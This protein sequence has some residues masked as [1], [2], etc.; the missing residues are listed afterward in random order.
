MKEWIRHN[1]WN[2]CPVCDQTKK[3]CR[4]NVQTNVVHCRGE[5]PSPSY[6]FLKLDKHGF[7]MFKLEAEIEE[8]S[9]QKKQDW[10]DQ[11]QR[12]REH[13]QRQWEQ[14]LK[15]QLSDQQRD[16]A[17][18]E[19]LSQ[20]TLTD[21]HRDQLKARGLTDEQI[22]EA[23]YR[24]VTQWQPLNQKVTAQLA[25]VSRDGNQLIT[26][27]SGIIVP[28]PNE[29]GQWVG[30]QLRRDHPE[31]GN[32]Y[33][34]SASERTRENRPTVK[35]RDGELPL[36]VWGTP[37]EDGV[38]YLCESP[39]IKPYLASLRLNHPVIGAAGANFACSP[40][41]LVRALIA[42]EA[43]KLIILPDAGAMINPHI[44]LQ[45]TKTANLLSD[46][47]YSVQFAWWGQM[48]KTA[49]DI[50]EISDD[51]LANME[52]LEAKDYISQG[53]QEQKQRQTQQ[54]QSKLHCLTY[55]VDLL[56][57]DTRLPDLASYIPDSGMI[58]LKSPKA[59]GKSWQIKELRKLWEATGKQ[60]I[61]L[62]PRIALGRTQ[63]V[64]WEINWIDDMGRLSNDVS[65]G[66][67]WDSLQKVSHLDW[68]DKILIIDEAELGIEHL[69]SSATC[70]AQRA[71][72][73][74]IFQQKVPECLNHGGTVFLSDADLTDVPVDY[75]KALAPTAPIFTIVNQAQPQQ[76]RVAF[77]TG[78]K[79]ETLEQLF[80]DLEQ[81][82][83]IT[84]ATD[85][86]EEAEALQRA[87]K[88][89]FPHK[90]VDRVDGK[91]C[92]ENY[93][94]E[95]VQDSN[96]NIEQNQPDVLIYTPSMGVGV[97]ITIDYF[98][99]VY[100]LFH[101]VLAPKD[102]RQMLG[103]I[104][105]AV[106]RIV[107][108]REKGMI[109][110]DQASFLPE[111]IKK[112]I[113]FN[114]KEEL[115]L[116]DLVNAMAPDDDNLEA[117]YQVLSE[118][119]NEGKWDNVHLETYAKIKARRNYGLSQLALQLR[120][121]LIEQGH[122]LYD[123][124]CC[125]SSGI[126][127]ALRYGKEELKQEQATAIA[128]AE[129]ISLEEAQDMSYQ[130]SLTEEERHQMTKAFLKEELPEA[131][132]TPDFVLNAVVQD[133]RKWL[134]A[135]KL[136]WFLNNPDLAQFLDQRNWLHHAKQFAEGEI[137]LPDV[138]S[139]SGKIKLLQ[140]IGLL[141][142]LD[143]D[144]PDKTFSNDD[145]EVQAFKE[146]CWHNRKRLRRLFGITVSKNLYPI[147]LLGMLAARIGLSLTGLPQKRING[148]QVRLYQVNQ[149]EL[150]TPHRIE[151]LNALDRKGEAIAQ[152]AEK[153]RAQG[154]HTP[155]GIVNKIGE[156][157]TDRVNAQEFSEIMNCQA[158][159]L[160]ERFRMLWSTI[161]EG[162][163]KFVQWLRR[164]VTDPEIAKVL[165]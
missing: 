73:L 60:I 145:E 81:G 152:K 11:K 39:G 77:Q 140:D 65:V 59:S 41:A 86:Q 43:K 122:D 83:K 124:Y 149:E 62:T 50:D 112:N 121:E 35:N 10:L 94:K 16:G 97:S 13:R 162:G 105:T 102:C 92:Q 5:N 123:F 7:G 23:G 31:D 22:E 49:G 44:H 88:A 100:G 144:N 90:R 20:L 150:V 52:S 132:L 33:I 19:I 71:Q 6:R 74:Q 1:H 45:N 79:D 159:T 32:K 91:T 55:P 128:N 160:D 157:V 4:T 148:K 134:N 154:C 117:I 15:K 136:F 126:G 64:E 46:W 63:A 87:I 70:K 109:N 24:S 98:D 106:P 103:R 30:Y 9:E 82:L 21:D 93:G 143:L 53:W 17:I 142:L 155:P 58:N 101:G 130:H 114:A 138:R 119:R 164:F 12:E 66:L 113:A 163:D 34:W 56:L 8:F 2:P 84:V 18:R 99:T 51:A 120:Q 26:P 161:A 137:F 37:N 165:A 108:C 3:G 95:W 127:D 115:S 48:E 28:I 67:C 68:R 118:I 36:G 153:A 139:Y 131:E 111:V 125:D 29:K 129:E 42:L 135:T 107:W 156:G 69:L 116:I 141:E 54:E 38:V 151:V 14:E 133:N 27:D 57:N 146:R 61:S 158:L 72:I 96:G 40:N 110:D 75:I 76:W 47:G 80:M 147:Q 89:R 25:G 85:S 78:K 104:R